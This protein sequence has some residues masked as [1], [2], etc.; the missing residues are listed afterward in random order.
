MPVA[1]DKLNPNYRVFLTQ[2]TAVTGGALHILGRPALV[3]AITGLQALAQQALG[4]PV[5]FPVEEVVDRVIAAADQFN[6]AGGYNVIRDF[7]DRDIQHLFGPNIT[8][9]VI[10]IQNYNPNSINMLGR[11]GD[12]NNTDAVKGWHPLLVAA[13]LNQQNVFNALVQ[14][15]ELNVNRR[16]DN[17][18]QR[19]ALM[20][21]ARNGHDDIVVTLL[22]RGARIDDQDGEGWTALM[23]AAWEGQGHPATVRILLQRGANRELQNNVHQTARTIAIETGHPEIAALLV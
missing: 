4:I 8:D 19:T 17:R 23:L 2:W 21:A 22:N 1:L 5:P 16:S 13:E 12:I 3:I 10:A 20:N 15:Q 7:A 6:D 18:W 9:L 14:M 11:V